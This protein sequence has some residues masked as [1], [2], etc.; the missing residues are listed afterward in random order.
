MPEA[1]TPHAGP[2]NASSSPVPT[3]STLGELTASGY[4]SRPVKDELRANLLKRIAAREPAVAGVLGYDDDV[5][6]ALEHAIIAGH[7][8]IILGERGQAKSRIIRSLVELL[9]EWL[10]VVT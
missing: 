9:D 3:I 6:P 7:D 1:T 4:V 10:P 8:V 2:A 5:L